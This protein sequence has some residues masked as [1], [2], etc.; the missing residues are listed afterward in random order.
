MKTYKS[1]IKTN[2]SKISQNEV[3]NSKKIEKNIVINTKI[4]INVQDWI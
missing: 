4:I 1:F 3:K 2:S